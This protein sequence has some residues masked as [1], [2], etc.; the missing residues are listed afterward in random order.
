MTLD[1][2]PTP[3][4]FLRGQRLTLD[5]VDEVMDDVTRRLASEREL[6]ETTAAVLAFVRAELWTLRRDCGA[7]GPAA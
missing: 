1:P 5:L 2:Y 7:T 6:G 4:D 3:D